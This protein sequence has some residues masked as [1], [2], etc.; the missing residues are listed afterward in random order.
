M[1]RG[2]PLLALRSMLKAELGDFSGANTARDAELNQLLANKQMQLAR[3]VEWAFLRRRWDV[4]VAAG[5][6]FVSLPN[7]E[8]DYGVTALQDLDHVDRVEVRWNDIWQ[9][10]LEGIGPG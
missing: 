6:Q 5:Q 8:I 10:V 4:S 9:P 2:T 7:T 3:E 1:A